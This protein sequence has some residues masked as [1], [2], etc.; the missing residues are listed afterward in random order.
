MNYKIITNTIGWVL[1]VEAAAL[2]L[3][4][5]CAIVYGEPEYITFIICILICGVLGAA[6]TFPSIKNR[7]MFSKEG[8]I[9]VALS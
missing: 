7:T 2:I 5:I 3:P 1:N 6:L 8:F 9:T 4:L